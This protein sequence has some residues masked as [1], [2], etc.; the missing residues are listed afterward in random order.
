LSVVVD[1]SVAAQWV[2]LQEHTDTA[3]TLLQS[4]HEL[5]A[6]DLIRAEVFNTLLRA[7][8]AKRLQAE[9]ASMSIQFF[10]RVPL[11]LQPTSAYA[12]EGF[13]IAQRHGGSV[14]DA[15]YIA[16]ARSLGA[17]LATGDERMASI[18]ETLKVPVYR[19]TT[20]FAALLD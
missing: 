10:E 19:L 15:C 20:G 11:R 1:A 2:V 9:A 4:P 17:P 5:V 16:L 12:T 3:R 8:R 18:A 13:A 14:Y 6:V 7:I